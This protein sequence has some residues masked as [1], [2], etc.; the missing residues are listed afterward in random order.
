MPRGQPSVQPSGAQASPPFPSHFSTPFGTGDN[1]HDSSPSPSGRPSSLQLGSESPQSQ[2][3]KKST[4]LSPKAIPANALVL[5]RTSPH[6]TQKRTKVS[7]PTPGT[8]L[9][10]IT[11]SS[12]L[13][14]GGFSIESAIPLPL[15]R[16]DRRK[17]G[18]PSSGESD[19]P[20]SWAKKSP[21]NPLRKHTETT[22]PRLIKS[23]TRRKT[24]S[25]ARLTSPQQ[26]TSPPSLPAIQAGPA[27]R[28]DSSPSESAIYK[29][30]PK[31]TNILRSD[32]R[33]LQ[34]TERQHPFRR[35][36]SFSRIADQNALRAAFDSLP[37][38][39]SASLEGIP[40]ACLAV[41]PP[42]FPTFFIGASQSRRS[43][44][45]G[46]GSPSSQG[47]ITFAASPPNMEGP[48]TFEAPELVEETI[49]KPEHNETV[50]RLNIMY[51][52]VSAIMEL[53]QSRSDPLAESVYYK[54]IASSASHICFISENQR[55]AEQIVLYARAMQLLTAALKLAKDEIK[56]N[57]LMNSKAVRNGKLGLD[58]LLH[59]VQDTVASDW[60]TQKR[61]S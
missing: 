33:W 20:K 60:Q 16:S 61:N 34:F 36:A 39:P 53:A 42:T 24:S 28:H 30:E 49:M 18:S 29:Y 51:G 8:T 50:E 2:P 47:S 17:E 12:S 27:S 56:L 15:L 58:V 48:I 21:P 46:E 35:S 37:K 9:S 3:P 25:P 43:S 11:Y 52:I 4:K 59:G 41:T 44:Q 7:S 19:S 22:P 1:G 14:T 5:H 26:F 38:T 55:R 13:P 10:P 54:D 45:Y 57:K 32:G 31:G 40:G 23:P 6:A